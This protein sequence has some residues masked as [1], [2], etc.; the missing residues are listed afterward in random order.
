[1][2]RFAERLGVPPFEWQL[3]AM[4]SESKRLMFCCS[5]Q[6]GKSSTA[7]IMA[8]H[9]AIY[10]PGSL[11]LLVS[12]G[13]R[14]SVELFRKIQAYDRK[15]GR[16]VAAV[17][18][19]SV[20]LELENGS[21]IVALPSTEARV[22]GYSSPALVIVDEAARVEDAYFHAVTPTLATGDGRLLLCS[23]PY[24]MQGFFADLW[25][26]G[27]DTWERYRVPATSV[28]TISAGFLAE[29]KRSMPEWLF[30]QEYMVEFREDGG[31]G[32]FSFDTIAACIGGEPWALS[33]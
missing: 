21:R 8:L 28:P 18:E 4:R 10:E 14:Q 24:G 17:A 26:E 23:T 33:S 15:L 7:A 6:S 9:T 19:S 20:R 30:A 29:Q 1:M 16:P 13:E 32:V 11:V 27:G 25:H 31:G 5:R 22:R 12:P 3:R 2:V